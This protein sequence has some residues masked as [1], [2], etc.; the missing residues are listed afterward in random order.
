MFLIDNILLFPAHGLL[1]VF[2]ELNNAVQQEFANEGEAI[3]TALSEL[4]MMLETGQ[5]TEEEFDRREKEL[6]D[7]LDE[8]ETRGGM[9]A[10]EED[11]DDDAEERQTDEEIETEA[12]VGDSQEAEVAVV[13]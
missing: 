5:V 3:R 6:L 12:E 1:A 10:E 9:S 2:R 4:Y 13:S 8:F 7:R 11:I